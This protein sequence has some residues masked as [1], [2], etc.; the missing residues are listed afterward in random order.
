MSPDPFSQDAT[1]QRPDVVPMDFRVDY[2]P[3]NDKPGEFREVH[4]VTLRK[5][6]SGDGTVWLISE[7]K[8]S[9]LWPF[10]EPYYDAWVKG[11]EEPV[12]GTPLDVLPFVP[13]E[14]V[15]RLKLIQIKT[16]EDL[17]ESNETVL[18]RIGMGARSLR[19]KARAYL[20]NKADSAIAD[21]AQ[22]MEAE[23]AELKAR[24]E[25]LIEQVNSLVDKPKRRK[26]EVEE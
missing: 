10:V 25:E 26:K 24:V 21:R 4:K 2:K 7:L 6:G 23:N 18:Q 22:K 12:I 16:A 8:T 3:V 13:K 20:A 9:Q 19:D 17:A 14:A 1:H 5:R 11:Q 15:A